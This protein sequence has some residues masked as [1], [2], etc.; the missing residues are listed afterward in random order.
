VQIHVVDTTPPDLLN[1]TAQPTA[2]WPPNHKIVPVSLSV[3][4]LDQC[5]GGVSCAIETVT[6]NE[7]ITGD[8][9][10]TGPLQLEL[11]AERQGSGAGRIYS[12]VVGCQDASGNTSRATVEVRVAHDQGHP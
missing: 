5:G 10:L 4:A 3:D 7:P 1:L 11:R 2:L 8:F 9:S 12:I 6:A